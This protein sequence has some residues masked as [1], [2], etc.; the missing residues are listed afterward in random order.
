MAE[1]STFMDEL[2]SYI[3]KNLKKGYTRESLKWALIDQGY[4]RLEVER[5]LKKS[6]LELA[7]EA[8]ILDTKPEI[9]YEMIPEPGNNQK[10]RIKT[11]K[12]HSSF[13]RD[14]FGF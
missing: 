14:L 13:W 6:D 1:K 10:V 5:A 2:V 11:E 8:P 4:S 3:K 7:S 9:K 12:H